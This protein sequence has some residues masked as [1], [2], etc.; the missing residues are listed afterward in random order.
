M[1]SSPEPL[2]GEFVELFGRVHPAKIDITH[3]SP[4]KPGQVH[5]YH[6]LPWRRLCSRV[7]CH[8]CHNQRDQRDQRD[9]GLGAGPHMSTVDSV[10]TGL[11]RWTPNQRWGGSGSPLHLRVSGGFQKVSKKDRLCEAISTSFFLQRV[12]FPVFPGFRF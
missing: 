9:R 8:N 6:Q 2:A 4:F 11:T 7:N 10:A 5:Q 12:E 1:T 3:P